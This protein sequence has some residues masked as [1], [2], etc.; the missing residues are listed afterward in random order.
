MDMAAQCPKTLDTP[1]DMPTPFYSFSA[2]HAWNDANGDPAVMQKHLATALAMPGN[3]C[4]GDA[5]A[6]SLLEGALGVNII[7]MAGSVGVS[8]EKLKRLTCSVYARWV[9]QALIEHPELM[10]VANEGKEPGFLLS[11]FLSLLLVLSSS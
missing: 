1:M 11:F 7:L 2:E 6:A 3:Y 9:D 8:A 10:D 4:W 5:T